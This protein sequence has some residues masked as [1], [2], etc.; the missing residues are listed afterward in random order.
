MANGRE[1]IEARTGQDA[2]QTAADLD[3]TQADADQ[4]A[5][6]ADQTASDA[7]QVASDDDQTLSERDQHASDRDQAAADW[8]RSHVASAASAREALE[9]HEASRAE[10]DSATRERGSTAADRS[11]TT[12]LRLTTAAQRD[13]V[14]RVRDRTAAA[15]DRTAEARD[16]AADAPDRAA[17]ARERHALEAG[18]LEDVIAP[19]R[20]LRISG[21]SS[22]RQ[23]ALERA[24]AAADRAAAAADRA[25]AASDRRDAGLDELTGIS[26]RGTGELALTHEI[27]RSRRAGGS[28]VLAVIDVDGLKAVNDDM[29]HAAGD[30]LLR[31]VATA[32]VSAMRSYDVTVRWGGDEFVCAMSDLTLEVAGER[33]A[34]IKRG[35]EARS[36]AAS[37]SVGLAELEPT[38]TL[39]ALIARADTAL[40]RAKT[41][42]EI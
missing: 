37:I 16:R 35:L 42:R 21:A 14:A 41:G 40:Y 27:D 8:E 3:Q 10:R 4:T 12:A 39:E 1:E 33:I 23:A 26:R 9:A 32:I 2:D 29:G 34:E 20:A 5:S 7:D 18:I 11:R 24:A 28:L 38:D 17:E 13:E 19:L 6:D 30:A 31:D 25:A 36:P 15:R 22:R